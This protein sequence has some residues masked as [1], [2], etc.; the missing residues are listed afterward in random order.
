MN[1]YNII[2]DLAS[3]ISGRH[4]EFADIANEDKRL[5][6]VIIED[7]L[8]DMSDNKLRAR[9]PSREGEQIIDGYSSLISL[10]ENETSK[11]KEENRYTRIPGLQ[12]EALSWDDISKM[13]RDPVIS[14]ALLLVKSTIKSLSYNVD[15]DDALQKLIIEKTLEE[16]FQNIISGLSTSYENGFSI[17]Q[18]F[19]EKRKVRKT[20]MNFDRNGDG[21]LSVL[22]DGTLDLIRDI[23]FISPKTSNIKY[24]VDKTTR[25]L[26]YIVKT[27]RDGTTKKIYIKDLIHCSYDNTF[28]KVFGRSKL[29]DSYLPWKI[30]TI[31]STGELSEIDSAKNPH[32]IEVGYPKGFSQNESNRQVDNSI[33]AFGIANKVASRS[34][35]ALPSETYSDGKTPKWYIKK[36]EASNKTSTD[37]TSRF[38]SFR[39][40]SEKNKA[41]GIGVPWQI[42]IGGTTNNGELSTSIDVMMFLLNNFIESIENSIRVHVL[43]DVIS[44]NMTAAKIVDYKFSIDRLVYG[45]RDAITKILQ[46]GMTLHSQMIASGKGVPDRI[47]D[48]SKL[49][50]RVGIPTIDVSAAFKGI[51]DAEDVE[52]TTGASMLTEK[53]KRDRDNSVN[54]VSDKNS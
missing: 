21:T 27:K 13:S 49:M 45:N 42:V 34:Y 47:A 17:G 54:R 11:H 10:F 39:A 52:Q 9:A 51:K 1:I 41:L 36:S 32:K 22:Y 4:K 50:E 19:F 53:A 46:I 28:N 25:E 5:A 3:V 12:T 23:T 20:G 48:I 2:T 33:I 37:N 29:V 16:H 7:G 6:E 38:E 26:A 24:Y 15:C 43:D 30:G 40:Y 18:K 44:M 35:Y 8:S 31:I 14:F